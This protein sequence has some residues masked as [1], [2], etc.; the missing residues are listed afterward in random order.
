ML[1]TWAGSGAKYSAEAQQ[2]FTRLATQPTPARK[3][4][5][6]DLI[7]SLSYASVWTKL[8]GLYIQAAAD[9]ATARTNLIQSSFGTSVVGTMTFT[10]DQGYNGNDATSSYLQTNFDPTVGS[11][12][13]ARNSASF[14]AWKYNNPVD[15]G[16]LGGLQDEK[17]YVFA[18][19]GDG[20]FYWTANG[21]GSTNAAAASNTGMFSA[22]RSAAGANQSYLGAIPG[23]TSTNASVALVA[24]KT[25]HIGAADTNGGST[26]IIASAGYGASLSAADWRNVNTAVGKYLT[27]IA[28]TSP[29]AQLGYSSDI[30]NDGANNFT[31][32]FAR[33]LDGRLICVYSVGSGSQQ[34]GVIKYKLS[35]DNGKTWTAAST[36]AS[37]TAGNT[38]TDTS[39]KVLAS[40]V[41]VISYMDEPNTFLTFP[42]KVIRGT[43]SGGV[44]TWGS[45][46]AVDNDGTSSRVLEM[47]NGTLLLGLY[48]LGGK[49]SA[50]FSTD[51]GLTWTG[52]VTISLPV[53]A[54]SFTETEFYQLANGT[55]VCL[56]R[57]ED[58]STLNGIY[59]CTSADNGQTWTVPTRV[60]NNTICPAP[61]RPS[62]AVTPSGH[63]LL[64]T[65]FKGST[66]NK[67]GYCYSTDAGV[68]WSTPVMYYNIGTRSYGDYIYGEGFYDSTTGTVMFAVCQGSF[69]TTA[70]V[71]FQQFAY[72]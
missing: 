72:S 23:S 37:P 18:Y 62:F 11:P 44:I 36:I 22:N 71:M 66:D 52:K 17:T 21:A 27:T 57:G 40:G 25:I 6:A 68:T 7:N 45:P 32:G 14:F 69:S 3:A 8:D 29:T 31:P 16:M 20:T 34:D 13:F 61:A 35:S 12:N 43:V 55:I 26:C 28:G 9:A 51:A 5:Y 24:G 38:L 64:F 60:I 15:T 56:A 67:T 49:I 2:F 42:T 53:G 19:R 63:L 54:V 70:Q 4:A 65:R 41:I 33:L 48:A 46:I 10:A 50:I 39:V 58:L 1:L 47:A 59:R 30:V